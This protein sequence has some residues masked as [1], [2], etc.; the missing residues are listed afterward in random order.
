[1]ADSTDNRYKMVDQ[2]MKK[3]GYEKSALLE[4][5]HVAQETFGYLD[6]DALKFI[7]K[8]LKAPY[9]KVYGVATFYHR[10]TMKPQG[11]HTVV[12]CLGTACYIKG[13]KEILSKLEEKFN[14]KVSQTT[15][16]ALVSLLSAR[17]VGSCSIAP[18]VLCDNKTYGKLSVEESLEKIEEILA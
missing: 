8:K 16:D 7:A 2:A 1:M 3:L 4:V 13:A 6:K 12:V 9:S 18:V 15:P 5:L 11:K 10:F 17:C 14:I